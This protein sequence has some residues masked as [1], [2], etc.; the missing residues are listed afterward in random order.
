MRPRDRYAAARWK[1]DNP[2]SPTEQTARA[3]ERAVD[4]AP[5]AV[6][7]PQGGRGMRRGP[8]Q[9]RHLAVWHPAARSRSRAA[10]VAWPTSRT[11]NADSTA[12]GA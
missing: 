8:C 9:G 10:L 11:T 3:E 2:R 4:V 7:L 1:P 6:L 5:S 12:T